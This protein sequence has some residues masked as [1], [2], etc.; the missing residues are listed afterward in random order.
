MGVWNPSRNDGSSPTLARNIV[1]PMA[2]E[3]D[4]D[5]A[6]AAALLGEPLEGD[7]GPPAGPED[8][9]FDQAVALL[10]APAPPARLGFPRQS[11]AA[12]A[13][14]RKCKEAQMAQAKAASLEAQL[15]ELGSRTK[16]HNA[17]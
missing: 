17:I 8:P 15:K 11:A 16:P 3:P 6:F 13:Y 9:A 1:G 2:Q 14:A 7:R 10:A 5:F 12:A 4:D